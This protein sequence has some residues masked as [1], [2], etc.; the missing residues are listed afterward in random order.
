MSATGVVRFGTF[1]LDA[2]SGELR[3]D[4]RVVHLTPQASKLLLLLASS[5]GRL[6]SREEIQKELWEEDTFVDFEHG[7]NKLVGQVR[8]ALED[9]AEAP[10]YVETLPRRGYRF[11]G[12]VEVEPPEPAEQEEVSVGR[13]E[14]EVA[15]KKSAGKWL[16]GAAAL[17]GGIWIL[18]VFVT[19]GL[20]GAARDVVEPEFTQLTS[21]IGE[22]L[23]PDFSPSG[24]F[25]VYSASNAEQRDIY[26]QRVSGANAINLTPDSLL[27]DTQPAFSPVGDQIAFR[28]ERDGG[29][30]FVMGATGE[31]VRRVT[32]HGF[33]PSWSPDGTEIVFS[34]ESAGLHT[35]TFGLGR[36]EI[37]RVDTGEVRP[38]L[39]TRGSAYQ[40]QWSPHGHQILFWSST[41]SKRWR[42]I[43]TVSPETGDVRAITHDEAT[44]WNPVWSPDGSFVYFTSARE[45]A[46]SLWRI[47]VEEKTG[48]TVGSAEFISTSVPAE[49]VHLTLSSDGKR[50]AYAALQS[51]ANLRQVSFDPA[52]GNVVG[53]PVWMT[54]TSKDKFWPSIS[55]DG[56]WVA[57]SLQ[58]AGSTMNIALVRPDGS[59][60]RMLTT[61]LRERNFMP[62]W[63]PDGSE[64]AFYSSRNSDKY[65]L[66]TI[67]ADGSGLQQ[68][69]VTPHG[70][71]HL[72][73]SPIS[74]E[75]ALR[76][77]VDTYIFDVTAA[78]ERG[79]LRKLARGSGMFE[80]TS[81]SPDGRWLAG[82]H[83]D[84]QDKASPPSPET[85][86]ALLALQS[87]DYRVLTEGAFPKWLS[88]GRR[89]VFQ[90]ID[91]LYLLDSES[92]DYRRILPVSSDPAAIYQG[93]DLARDGGTIYYTE[94]MTESDIWMLALQPEE[95]GSR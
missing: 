61:D 64:I 88:D 31:S 56:R 39:K 23:F 84:W 57:F 4:G 37:V 65:E 79:K 60:L 16:M 51:A 45:G 50:I 71:F 75:I 86:I 32:D 35:V 26:L 44:D 80:A 76:G 90:K 69:T 78:S 89:L 24:E 67:R 70:V 42:D 63:S 81:W 9:D 72:V 29:G 87:E 82:M 13:N 54:R 49:M 40:P 93:I 91:G 47:A 21:R 22:E 58:G 25:L 94:R 5:S 53:G 20:G 62:N 52:T 8:T 3:R 59:G 77:G 36:L 34:T 27:D 1:R 7:I 18:T 92:G 30:I 85:K 14:S 2:R 33:N 66:W 15:K 46:T 38:V 83:Y 6:V 17:G 41:R 28:S 48:A 19:G 55:P 74:S 73:W 43:W 11:L 12:A 68:R 10:R 95:G